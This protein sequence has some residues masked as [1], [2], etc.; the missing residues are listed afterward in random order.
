MLDAGEAEDAAESAWDED[1]SRRVQ[2][3]DLGVRRWKR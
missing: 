3:D 2:G 1:G